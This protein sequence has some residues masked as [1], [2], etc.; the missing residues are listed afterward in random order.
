MTSIIGLLAYQLHTD[1]LA[2]RA[3]ASFMLG[4]SHQMVTWLRLGLTGKEYKVLLDPAKLQAPPVATAN[5]FY[6]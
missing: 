2:C 5:T 4:D 3:F 1:R 6:N